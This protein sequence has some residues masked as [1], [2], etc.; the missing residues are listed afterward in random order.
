MQLARKQQEIYDIV[1]KRGS[2]GAKE[3]KKFNFS[4]SK[5]PAL[6]VILLL[7][8]LAFSLSSQF[9]SLASMKRDIQSMK[10][11][12]T[13]LKQKNEALHVE[14]Q[15]FQ[16]DAFVEKT[17]REKLGLVKS[18]ETRIVAVPPGTELKKIQAPAKDSAVIDH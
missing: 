13:T 11:E 16:S 7:V 6:I 5:L 12:V 4:R 14:L 3:Q 15:Q 18:G 9:G 8:Y 1:P 17:A 2:L 10:Q